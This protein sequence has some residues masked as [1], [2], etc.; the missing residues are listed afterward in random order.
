MSTKRSV[1]TRRRFVAG[2]GAVA[3][4]VA[5]GAVMDQSASGRAV[6]LA[7]LPAP[8]DGLPVSQH[9]WDATL[10]RDEY[11]NSVP[12]RHAR[13]LFF[14]VQGT[15][16]PRYVRLLEAELR[17]LEHGY[18]W[19]P[20]G[21]LFTA[22]W[23]PDYF[24][25]VLRTTSPI[26]RAKPLSEFELPT[27]DTH[28]LCVHLASDSESNLVSC[29]Q[30]LQRGLAPILTL[31]ET[32]TG[33]AGAGLPAANQK[34]IVGIPAGDPVA[35]S[36]P[37]YMGFKSALKKNQATE[38]AVTLSSGDFVH[39]TTMTV[40]YMRLSLDSWYQNLSQDERV[41]RM[42]SP[43][44]TPREAA[45]F[46][47]DAESN[48]NLIGQAINRYG[49]IGHSQA[50]ARARR[51]GKPIILRRDFDTADYGRS[52]LHFVSLQRSIAD[53]VATRTAMNQ[54]AA[55][56]Q[57]PAI[58]DTVNN[59]INEFIFVLKRGNYILPARGQRSFPLLPGR[60]SLLAM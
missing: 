11:G 10:R 19:R 50:S 8:V 6:P 25:G 16:T 31:R 13:L 53:F 30:A 47:T 17:R 48:P 27:I 49:V 55:Q 57:N 51:G 3:A 1:F 34:G 18:A 52:G 4:A 33:F 40:S 38:G 44:T 59:G 7:D 9:A 45:A 29:E 37:L 22:G 28:D 46:T 35:K 15:P 43:Q 56:L 60:A 2:S 5:A 36:S 41:A 14:D 20:E 54:A 42:Y 12:P 26:P 24:Q 58:T 21:L 23:S 39:G 32:R